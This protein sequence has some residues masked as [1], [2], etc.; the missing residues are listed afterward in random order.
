MTAF[1]I[2]RLLLLPL[3]L[4][5]LAVFVFALTMLLDP[6]DRVS[7]YVNQTLPKGNIED[8]VVRHGLDKPAYVQFYHWMGKVVRGDLG[9]SKTAQQ[10]VMSAILRFLPATIELSLWSIIPVILGGIGL[11]VLSSLYHNRLIDH[12]LRLVS[13]VGWSIPTFVFGLLVLMFFYAKLSW[14]PAG[15][16]SDWAIQ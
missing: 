9:W 15:R 7:L 6:L 5:G 14:F 12:I 4:L 10:P 2:R 13:I 11:G 1:V 16:L 8:L 3:I